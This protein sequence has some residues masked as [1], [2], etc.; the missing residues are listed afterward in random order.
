[1]RCLR[2][3]L[4]QSVSD[5]G[6]NYETLRKDFVYDPVREW[7]GEDRWADYNLIQI[8]LPGAK[9]VLDE[10]QDDNRMRV[11]E[12]ED[13]ADV[14]E[15]LFPETTNSEKSQQIVSDMN[16]FDREQE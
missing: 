4:N 10:K 11:Y 6:R 7:R 13:E 5:S 15:K 14:F 12:I 2:E 3:K 1:M 9:V 16:F 8:N